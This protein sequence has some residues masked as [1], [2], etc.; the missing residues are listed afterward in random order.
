MYHV[1]QTAFTFSSRLRQVAL[2]RLTGEI[3]LGQDPKL[4]I[5]DLAR[6]AMHRFSQVPHASDAASIRPLDEGENSCFA[7]LCFNRT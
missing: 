4:S 3:A 1:F 2:P 5:G 7:G 6:Q